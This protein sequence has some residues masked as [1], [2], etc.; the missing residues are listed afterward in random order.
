VNDGEHTL[1]SPETVDEWPCR[2]CG[3][4]AEVT[5]GGLDALAAANSLAARKGEAPLDVA[6]ILLCEACAAEFR[7]ACEGIRNQQAGQVTARL[8]RLKDPS[9]PRHLLGEDELYVTKYANE[10]GDLVKR[11]AEVRAK[12]SKRGGDL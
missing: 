6:K 12:A 3:K 10:G 1:Y 7:V 2:R 9:T 8:Q 4:P 11:A 5:Q